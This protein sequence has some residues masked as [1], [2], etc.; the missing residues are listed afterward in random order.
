MSKKPPTRKQQLKQ[1]ALGRVKISHEAN[2]KRYSRILE[3]YY[4]HGTLPESGIQPSALEL[5]AQGALSAV[6]VSKALGI[7]LSALVHWSEPN[8]YGDHDKYAQGIPFYYYMVAKEMALTLM[9]T[10]FDPRSYE[11]KVQS[12]E[13]GDEPIFDFY[14]EDDAHEHTE[15]QVYQ[16]LTDVPKDWKQVIPATWEPVFKTIRHHTYL[17]PDGRELRF[18]HHEFLRR[19]GR[20]YV[21]PRVAERYGL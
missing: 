3:K 17:F 7:R 13:D 18:R 12:I 2:Q 21:C 5:Y 11:E 1:T 16:E 4:L 8:E 9:D 20:M 19:N 6:Q 10:E 14:A 15:E